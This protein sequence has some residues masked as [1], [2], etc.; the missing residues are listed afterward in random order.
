MSED[1]AGI[2]GEV[3]EAIASVGT[4]ATVDHVSGRSGPAYN[5]GSP[6]TAAGTY[7][8][9]WTSASRALAAGLTMTEGNRA[10]YLSAP[11]GITPQPGETITTPS[12]TGTILEVL[13][14]EP[15]GVTVM[16]IVRVVTSE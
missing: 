9:V 7:N 12:L 2:A 13:P 8:L 1:W 15:A 6:T 5:P 11:A 14:L 16:Y 4:T 10:A 3:A